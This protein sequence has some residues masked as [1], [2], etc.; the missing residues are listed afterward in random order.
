MARRWLAGV[1]LCLVTGCSDNALRLRTSID[2]AVAQLATGPDQ[3]EQHVMYRPVADR[4]K[5]YW[6]VFLPEHRTA[7]ADLVARGMP[8]S[9]AE[10]IFRDLAYVNVGDGKA[11]IVYQEGERLSFTSYRTVEEIRIPELL[12]AQ[13]DDL[14]HVVVRKRD[15]MAY[16]V[17]IR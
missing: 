4:H 5:P 2:A 6:L 12:V 11:L 1:I 8:V 10:R 7:A 13:R 14:S 9:I 3:V 16:I 15:G 17:G